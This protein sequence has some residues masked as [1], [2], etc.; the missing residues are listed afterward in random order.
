M[1]SGP[2]AIAL[3]FEDLS[4]PSSPLLKVVTTETRP[5]TLDSSIDAFN[6]GPVFHAVGVGRE[7]E[8]SFLRITTRMA[9]YLE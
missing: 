4:L 9:R 5:D 6:W 2:V 8:L 1:R 3:S 7:T